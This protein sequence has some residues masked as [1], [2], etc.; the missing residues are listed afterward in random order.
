MSD[1]PYLFILK[2]VQAQVAQIRDS[3]DELLRV[4]SESAAKVQALE[5]NRRKDS[6]AIKDHNNRLIK[7]ESRVG[8]IAAGLVVFFSAGLSVGLSLVKDMFSGS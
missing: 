3:Q 4:T 6:D 1:D 8:P 2:D 7:L 5:E